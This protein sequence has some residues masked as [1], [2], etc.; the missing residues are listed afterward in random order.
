MIEPLLEA[1]PVPHLTLVESLPPAASRLATAGNAPRSNGEKRMTQN[2]RLIAAI[3]ER[4][5]G[6]MRFGP[7][8]EHDLYTIGQLAEHLEVSLRTLRFYE[9][10]GLLQPDRRGTKRLYSRQDLERL[11]VI[12]TLR[13]MEA[14]LTAIK[15][16]MGLIGERGAEGKVFSALER[17]LG[18]LA[19]DNRARIDHLGELNRRIAATMACL[20]AA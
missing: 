2:A 18:D 11:K 10:A 13:E 4:L 1:L 7:I 5:S 19:S 12:V 16:L 14:S 8:A 9:Q 15:D 6:V 17:L 20:S 3:A